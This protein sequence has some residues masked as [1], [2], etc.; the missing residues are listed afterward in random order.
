MK[1]VQLS[2][3]ALSDIV[4][5]AREDAPNECCGLLVGDA[6]WIARAV[7]ARNLQASST[8]YLIDP[9]DHFAAI[10]EAR[11]AGQ[12]VVG[13][14]HSH[15]RAAAVP[16]ETDVAESSGDPDF[17]Y[18]IV[19]LE[20]GPDKEAARAFYLRDGSFEAVDLEVVT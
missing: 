8:R 9:V 20:G 13:A 15:V 18:L 1:S 16:S 4:R 7:R 19:S 3:S 12:T 11:S 14:Y 2:Q 6:H 5:H 17:V 10:R